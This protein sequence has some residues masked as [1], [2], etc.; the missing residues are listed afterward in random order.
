MMMTDSER[1][2][3]KIRRKGQRPLSD[4]ELMN[5]LLDRCGIELAVIPGS[6]VTPYVFCLLFERI[7]D[8]LDA[9]ESRVESLNPTV[10]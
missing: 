5:R 10:T 2:N 3:E 6:P 7:L 1:L 9:V 8:R 4:S